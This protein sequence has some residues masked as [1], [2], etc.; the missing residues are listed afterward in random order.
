MIDL[1]NSS[2]RVVTLAP[3]TL[4]GAQVN[5]L[6]IPANVKKIEISI[7]GLSTNGTSMP[8]LRLGDS[9]GVEN[10]GYVNS[11]SV[12]TNV[13]V[14][15]LSES[16]GFPASN[17]HASDSVYS[18]IMTLIHLGSNLW[19]WAWNGAYTDIAVTCQGGGNK[20]LSAELDRLQFTMLNGTDVFDAGTIRVRY[21][22]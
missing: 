21:Y 2:E 13:A 15:T 19:A 4:T 20:T 9:G 17:S 7:S 11:A 6:N 18:G 10:T 16:S 22:Y 12:V 8:L 5:T 3:Q 1:N 14:G